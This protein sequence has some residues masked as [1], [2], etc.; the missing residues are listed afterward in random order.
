[1]ANNNTYDILRSCLSGD[2]DNN[3][4]RIPHSW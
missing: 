3:W 1:M 2:T 4:T